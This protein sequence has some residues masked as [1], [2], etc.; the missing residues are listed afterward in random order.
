MRKGLKLAFLF[1][2]GGL[3][4]CMIE[5]WF[6][7]RTHPSMLVVG[8][9]CFLLCGAMNEVI[10]WYMPFWEQM[11]IGG[12]QITFV[13]FLSGVILNLILHLD[14]WDYSKMPMN[15]LGQICI[16]FSIAWIFLSAVAIILDDYL[17]YWLFHEEKPHY[18]WR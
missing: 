18:V 17:R 7:G 11:L 6:R 5:F 8:G 15:F 13:E 3:L 10:P 9:L 14:V 2:V 16:P 12:M 4:Y 1:L